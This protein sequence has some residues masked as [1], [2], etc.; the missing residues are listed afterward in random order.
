[1]QKNESMHGYFLPQYIFFEETSF[2]Q[3]LYP[4]LLDASWKTIKSE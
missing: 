4:K 2:I 1:M 3:E